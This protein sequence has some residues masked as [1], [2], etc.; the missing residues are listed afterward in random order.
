MCW[1]E[2]WGGINTLR[3]V[4]ERGMLD[5]REDVEVGES[6]NDAKEDNGLYRCVGGMQRER[7]EEGAHSVLTV[8]WVTVRESGLW[9]QQKN[10]K[11]TIPPVLSTIP[12][13]TLGP[14][15]LRRYSATKK[16]KNPGRNTNARYIFLLS[17]RYHRPGGHHIN[18]CG[19]FHTLS[20]SATVNGRLG[21]RFP[22]LEVFE[23]SSLLAIIHSHTY[24][25]MDAFYTRHISYL[26]HEPG[27]KRIRD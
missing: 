12:D 3:R 16:L 21:Y 13:R 27:I 8:K 18:S 9:S 15:P 22:V 25:P 11:R 19:S 1:A 7:S 10:K 14:R 6:A 24:L 20:P 23:D 5:G 26:D 4:D 2:R 17:R